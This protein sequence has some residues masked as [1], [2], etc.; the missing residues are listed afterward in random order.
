MNDTLIAN[1]AEADFL[2]L[3]LVLLSKRSIKNKMP[4]FMYSVSRQQMIIISST[5]QFR[6]SEFSKIF[7]SGSP[8]SFRPIIGKME[9]NFH[10]FSAFKPV[11]AVHDP[12]AQAA[13]PKHREQTKESEGASDTD[14][15][16][17]DDGLERRHNSQASIGVVLRLETE[18]LFPINSDGFQLIADDLID[19]NLHTNSLI[20]QLE[21]EISL[22]KSTNH[23]LEQALSAM[24]QMNTQVL[25]DAKHARRIKS[26]RKRD[27]GWGASPSTW[28]DSK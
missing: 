13:E 19:R 18:A 8:V 6:E 3:R 25:N 17:E 9:T 28:K 5:H 1:I 4:R 7:L 2:E 20:S 27:R 14:C 15:V 21:K 26:A 12:A 23:K 16:H 10:A 22:L 11:A 24:T